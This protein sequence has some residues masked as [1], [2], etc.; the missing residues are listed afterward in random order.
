[1]RAAKNGVSVRTETWGLRPAVIWNA[2]VF[3]AMLVCVCNF[4]HVFI[5]LMASVSAYCTVDIFFDG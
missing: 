1:M 5:F 2:A 3:V 4:V